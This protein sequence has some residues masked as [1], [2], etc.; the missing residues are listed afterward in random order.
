MNNFGLPK[1]KYFRIFIKMSSFK[2]SSREA[3]KLLSKYLYQTYTETEHTY[4]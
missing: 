1:F 2:D 3:V 4:K